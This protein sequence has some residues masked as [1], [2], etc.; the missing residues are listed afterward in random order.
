MAYDRA[1]DPAYHD[2]PAEPHVETSPYV[3]E[4]STFGGDVL[5]E[6]YTATP[7]CRDCL[8][9]MLDAPLDYYGA[10]MSAFAEN[11]ESPL[12]VTIYDDQN[13]Q[14]VYGIVVRNAQ[15]EKIWDR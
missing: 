1:A 15:S 8:E 3:T 2:G 14:H 11:A 7:P 12:G 10:T 5:A 4:I 6:I 9:E 13:R